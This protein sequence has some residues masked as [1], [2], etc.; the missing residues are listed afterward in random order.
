MSLYFPPAACKIQGIIKHK[1]LFTFTPKLVRRLVL[2]NAVY[3]LLLFKQSQTCFLQM[4]QEKEKMLLCF[5][6][7]RA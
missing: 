1:F 6:L 3:D 4:L 5:P 2:Y 7:T